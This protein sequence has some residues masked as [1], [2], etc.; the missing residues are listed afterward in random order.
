M[1]DFALTLL[2]LALIIG[3]LALIIGGSAAL[4]WNAAR[5]VTRYMLGGGR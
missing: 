4:G 1:T 2:G 3:G 5:R